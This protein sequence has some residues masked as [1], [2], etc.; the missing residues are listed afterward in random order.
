[1]A[2]VIR[3]I[4]RG[5]VAL[6]VALLLVSAGLALWLRTSLPQVE[7]E[8]EVAALAA[9]VTVLRDAHGI[10]HIQAQSIADAT[11]TLGFLHAQDR[12]FQM[13]IMRRIGRGRLA[14]VAGARM[15][16]LDRRMRTFGLAQLAEADA[17][18][19][20]PATLALFQAYAEGV[21]GFLTTRTGALPPEFLAFPEAPAPWTVA[22]SLLWMKLMSLSLTADWAGE[23]ERAALAPGLTA[24]QLRELYPELPGPISY[25]AMAEP[26]AVQQALAAAASAVQP[27]AGS[28]LWAFAGGRTDTGKPILAND[29]H[30]GLSVPNVWYLLRIETPEGVLAGASAPGFPLLVLGHN[31]RVAWALTNGYGD[32][33]DV[34]IERVDPADPGRYLTPA[35]PKPFETREERIAVRFGET[36]VMTVRS[37]RHGPVISDAPGRAGM[38]PLAE[39][40]V[41][42]L[43]HM[44]LMAGDQTP[45]AL[46]GAQQANSVAEAIEALRIMQGPQQNVG[47]ADVAGRIGM[48]AAGKV[49][50]R[51]SPTAPLPV[52]GWDGSHDWDGFIPYEALPRLVDPASGGLMN[53]NNR[54]AGPDYA[55]DLGHAYAAPFRAEA[56]AAA[57][58]VQGA[59]QTLASSVAVQTDATSLAARQLL[60]LVDWSAVGDSLP[61][62][63]VQAMRAWDAKMAPDRPEPLV[64]YAFLRSLVRALYADELGDRFERVFTDDPARVLYTLTEARQW[65]DVQGTA[66]VEDCNHAV[67]VAFAEAFQLLQGRYGK[68]WHAWRWGEAHQAYFRHMLFGFIPGLRDLFD[69]SVAHGG[70]RNSPNAGYV[71]FDEATLFQQFHGAGYRAVY[72]LADLNRSRF[73]QAVGQSGNIF[74]PY[75][76]DLLPLWAAGKTLTLEPLAEGRGAHVLRLLPGGRD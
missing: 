55:Y 2:R 67:R 60:S 35:G 65:C 76:A 15:L 17:K 16:G 59:P 56:I 4:G 63:L 26:R 73:M 47:F 23:L 25:A 8:R 75:Y 20:P 41:L 57:M 29:P 6:V 64:Y 72:D 22:D 62:D 70:A 14:E 39:G 31:G 52:P 18:A 61:A 9:P 68:D 48:I 12:L 37:T 44:G 21:N 24:Q 46:L 28:N 58:A 69:V 36:D 51:R 3:W 53:A 42:A 10:P 7:G 34:F 45:A 32:T 54:Q 30:L 33:A 1:M 11:R 49:P 40:S 5:F 27:G 43:E 66:A 13:E 38:P 19:M 71:N 74:S 50:L